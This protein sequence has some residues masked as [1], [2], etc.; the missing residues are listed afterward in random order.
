MIVTEVYFYAQGE[1]SILSA[2]YRDTSPLAATLRS[3]HLARPFSTEK[4]STDA[5]PLIHLRIVY[6]ENDICAFALVSCE[7][8]RQE[9]SRLNDCSSS[10]CGAQCKST[11]HIARHIH[12]VTRGKSFEKI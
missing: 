6:G 2:L 1:R 4:V 3:T 9:P 8:Q 5:T 11:L 12:L 10:M 7:E